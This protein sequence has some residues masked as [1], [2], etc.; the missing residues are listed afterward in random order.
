MDTR[1]Y[2][3]DGHTLREHWMMAP[4]DYFGALTLLAPDVDT[5]MLPNRINVFARE[6]IRDGHE[7]APR[8]V[9]FQGG[10]GSAAP[11]M[12]PIGSWLDTALNHFRVI[13]IDQRGTGNSHPLEK[14]AVTSVGAP[15]VQAAYLSCFR[16]DSIVRD[17]EILRHELQGD[18]PWAALG[19]SFGGFTVTCYLSQE[20][21]GLSEAF[22]A[23]GL[24]SATKHADEVYRLTYRSMITRNRE[25]FALYNDDEATAWYVATHLADVDEFLPTGERLTPARFRQLGIVLGY[26]YGPEQLHFLLE[27][28]VWRQGGQRKLRPQFLSRVSK[29]LSLADNPLFGVLHESIYAQS[30]TGATAWSAQRVRSEFPEFM[31]PEVQAGGSAENDLR[32]EGR[33]FYF[34][35]EHVFPWQIEQD[36]DLAPMAEAAQVLAFSQRWPELYSSQALAENTVPTA[37]WIYLD[38]VL[39]PYQ[40]SKETADTIRGLKPLITNAFHHDGLRTGGPQ[41]I[42]R[43][44]EAVRR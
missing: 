29:V 28:P 24:P 26:S 6:Y 19:Q 10:P 3:I 4:L 12:A 41:M 34:T 5:R 11:R 1:T 43:L 13:L 27:D 16:Q 44:I 21:A 7:D 18:R 39:V 37:A 31:L 8:L 36:P 42:E 14:T 20:P 23:A 22:I 38:D 15:E 17:A 2:R 30:S 32:K 35:G 33:G 25:F 40:L 9:F